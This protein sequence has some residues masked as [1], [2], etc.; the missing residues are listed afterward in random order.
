MY[1]FDWPT[2]VFGGRLGACHAIEIPFVFDNLAAPGAPEFTGGDAPQGLATAIHDAWVKFMQSGDPSTPD[3]PRWP[4]YDTS[5]RSTM[6][7]D[8]ESRVVD[9]PDG[10]LR[11]IWDG[12]L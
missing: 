9:D 5:K 1:R 7:L 4:R 6:L 11:R 8:D 10:A 2:P 12:L 3:L